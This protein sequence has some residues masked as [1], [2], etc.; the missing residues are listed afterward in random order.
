MLFLEGQTHDLRSTATRGLDPSGAAL[1]MNGG[2]EMGCQLTSV[3]W[4]YG[5]Q[6]FA[7]IDNGHPH[8]PVTRMCSA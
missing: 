2:H 3:Q 8:V 1:D 6:E 5:L 4:P 7:G